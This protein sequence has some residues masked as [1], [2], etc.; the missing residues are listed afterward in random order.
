MVRDSAHCIVRYSSGDG[1]TDPGWVGKERVEA[2]FAA[3]VKINVNPSV[4]REDEIADRVCALDGVWVIVESLEKPGVSLHDESAGLFICPE[5]LD[6]ISN[7]VSQHK[8]ALFSG[9]PSTENITYHVLI[10]LVQIHT[11]LLSGLPPRRYTLVYVRLMYDLR[12]ERL[13]GVESIA[14][15]RW[16]IR[17]GNGVCCAIFEQET[18]ES[19]TRVDEEANDGQVDHQ[20]DDGAAAHVGGE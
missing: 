11:T 2:T 17:Q 8:S 16:D 1:A 4:V 6:H 14:L 13:H 20:E 19:A 12:N 10:V 7:T 15:W 18:D 5:L 3:V 9:A